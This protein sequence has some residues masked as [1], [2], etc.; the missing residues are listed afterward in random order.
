MF[1]HLKRVIFF[2]LLIVIG[3]SQEKSVE[4]Y[5]PPPTDTTGTGTSGGTAEFAFIASAGTCSDAN[6]GGDFQ[7]GKVLGLDAKITV[8]VNVTKT[9]DWTLS[10]NSLNGLYL[11]ER[12]HS[13]PP[14]PR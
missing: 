13:P 1:C 8:T 4:P 6:A 2:V 5:T 10:T 11:L 7:A 9:G 14:V 12:V 3:C